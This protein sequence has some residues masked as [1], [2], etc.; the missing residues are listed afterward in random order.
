MP[1]AE[2]AP[3]EE[4]LA[5]EQPEDA[6]EPDL[7]IIDPHHHLWDMRGEGALWEQ[8]VYLCEEMAEEVRVSGH[9]VVQTVFAQCGAFY[10]SD[11]PEEMRCVGETE[12]VH[13]IAAMSRS[14]K[15]GNARL[16]TGIFST[17]DLRLGAAAEPVL[18]A[19]LAAS[20]NFR[21]IR[22]PFPSDLNVQFQEGYALLGKH[23]LSFDNYSPDYER[24]PALAKLAAAHPDVPI[25][26]NHLG[27]KIDPDASPAEV[28]R[29][30]ECIASI[31]PCPNAVIKCGGAQQRVGR[32]W[33]PPFHMH[34]RQEGP[35]GSE[36]L[37][38][39][40]FPFYQYAIDA[41]GPERCMFESNFPVDKECVSYRA[42]WNLMKRIARKMGLSETEKTSL[43]SGTAARVYRLPPASPS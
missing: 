24:L 36:E 10:R 29:W 17:A 30:R 34:K 5:R 41:F 33:E 42:L 18:Q 22:S 39:L 38:E 4:W 28:A 23:N 20:P 8:N 43:F 32:D 27:G 15:Y 2:N 12:F 26:V 7:P 40:L 35:L 3:L 25:I 13:G 21:G 6:L 19:H 37:C 9:N 11:G 1:Y 31:A 14:G 16:C